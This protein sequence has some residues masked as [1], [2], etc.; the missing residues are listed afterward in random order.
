MQ[1]AACGGCGDANG[2]GG[3]SA[4]DA[5]I[6]L[7]AAVGTAPCALAVCDANGDGR[8]SASDALRILQAAVGIP[9][10]FHCDGSPP[11]T[12]TTTTSSTT[13]S[14]SSTTTTTVSL[15]PANGPITDLRNDCSHLGYFYVLGSIVEGLTTTG[16]SVVIAQTDGIDVLGYFGPVTGRRTFTLTHASVNGSD[17]FPILDA[18]SGGNISTDGRRLNLTII[19]DGQRFDFPGARWVET[20]PLLV[21]ELEQRTLAVA[22]SGA[23]MRSRPS[24]DA[25]VV[26]AQEAFAAVR[27]LI[28]R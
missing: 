22:A 16:D 1:A 18:G 10:G 19:V 28:G 15:C 3:I 14:T 2:D 9:V 11:T 27:E 25:S 24:G 8:L 12:T 17:F 4:T 20:D 26:S 23:A 7:Q 21:A 13:S 5:L 6:A